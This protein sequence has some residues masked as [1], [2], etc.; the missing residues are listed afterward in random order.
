MDKMSTKP[1]RPL[2]TVNGY[3]PA[4]FTFC[5]RR[6]SYPGTTLE[7]TRAAINAGAKPGDALDDD[8]GLHYVLASS[9]G[10]NRTPNGW[11]ARRNIR[12]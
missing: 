12:S 7:L 4:S 3:R 5:G 2:G 6:Y 1:P 10:G 8:L 9:G 11:W